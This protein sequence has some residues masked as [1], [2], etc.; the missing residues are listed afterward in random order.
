MEWRAVRI[1]ML[2]LNARKEFRGFT[3]WCMYIRTSPVSDFW[4]HVYA[5][6]V[7][8]R[9]GPLFMLRNQY[10]QMLMPE[11][12][13]NWPHFS[14]NDIVSLNFSNTLK[15]SLIWPVQYS[16]VKRDHSTTMFAL[17]TFFT[18]LAGWDLRE[19]LHLLTD[20]TD[21]ANSRS[22]CRGTCTSQQKA[23]VAHKM[24]PH[25]PLT[26]PRHLP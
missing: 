15:L 6:K 21:L 7:S 1:K 24:H 20:M 10:L 22:M 23:I 8:C 14:G 12:A 18:G 5:C 4:L 26:A 16:A 13:Y 17:S 2:Q 25:P 3:Q 11:N 19:T 9:A